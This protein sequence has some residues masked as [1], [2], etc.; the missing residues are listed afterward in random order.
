MLILVV[1]CLWVLCHYLGLGLSCF[2]IGGG[3]GMCTVV[4]PRSLVEWPTGAMFVSLYCTV[5]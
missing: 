1:Q 4:C 3:A 2:V 5:I